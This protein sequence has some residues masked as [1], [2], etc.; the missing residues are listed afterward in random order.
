MGKDGVR[1]TEEMRRSITDFPR[2]SDIMG[3][4]SWY[5]LVEQ[6]AWGFSKTR[7][8]EP[9]WHL[10]QHKAEFAWSEEMEKA[11]VVAK[12][13]IVRLVENCVRCFVPG[14]DLAL[15]TDWSRTGVSYCLWQKKCS[16]RNTRGAGS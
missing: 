11:F 8:M 5:G 7:L 15:V 6:V 2:P 3:I 10:L 13:E 1:P 4:Q 12:A 16:C 9:F 14:K